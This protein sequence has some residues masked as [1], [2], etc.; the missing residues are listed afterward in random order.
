[1]LCKPDLA[2]YVRKTFLTRT[3]F[4]KEPTASRVGRL[5]LS[6]RGGGVIRGR[7]DQVTWI[8][9]NLASTISVIVNNI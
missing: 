4:T 1:M 7:L 3:V 8:L 5:R 9:P 2:K 6:S